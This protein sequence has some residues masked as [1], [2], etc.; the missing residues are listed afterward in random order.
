ML[1]K[2]FVVKLKNTLF[3]FLDSCTKG[4]A[5][6]R[7][8]S[9]LWVGASLLLVADAAVMETTQ[10]EIWKSFCCSSPTCQQYST[11]SVP[12]SVYPFELNQKRVF[13]I[14]GYMW[15]SMREIFF[16][17]QEYKKIVK[18]RP[19]TYYS[20]CNENYL[21]SLRSQRFKKR[22]NGYKICKSALE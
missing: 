11:D 21:Q 20:R 13:L 19:L 17:L 2:V 15:F 3:L 5:L 18:L 9:S 6:R 4:T 14:N 1:L 7:S 22:N 12:T 16:F 8:R 10:R